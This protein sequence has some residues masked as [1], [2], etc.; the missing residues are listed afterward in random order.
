V[1]SYIGETEDDK[2]KQFMMVEDSGKKMRMVRKMSDCSVRPIL[3]SERREK[4]SKKDRTLSHKLPEYHPTISIRSEVTAFMRPLTYFQ[5]I[6]QH[7]LLTFT[8]NLGLLCAFRPVISIA[9]SF[10]DHDW[11]TIFR[12]TK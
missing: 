10:I 6:C 4:A 12:Y 3:S 8:S 5:T 1:S 2:Q 7:H 11:S 9:V